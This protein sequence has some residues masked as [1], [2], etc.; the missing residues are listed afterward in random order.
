MTT[1]YSDPRSPRAGEN[2]L[3]EEQS[4]ASQLASEVHN[5][6]ASSPN[7]SSHHASQGVLQPNDVEAID[8]FLSSELGKLEDYDYPENAA[9]YRKSEENG[10]FLQE[11]DLSSI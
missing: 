11:L 8:S 6:C 4:A 7:G 5:H 9:K 1:P 10:D 3:E 2:N